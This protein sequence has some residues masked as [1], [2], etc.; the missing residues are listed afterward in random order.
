MLVFLQN[1]AESALDRVSL[2][3]ALDNQL[4]SLINGVFPVFLSEVDNNLSRS[5]NACCNMRGM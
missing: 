4:M 2:C 3:L 1:F 5:C